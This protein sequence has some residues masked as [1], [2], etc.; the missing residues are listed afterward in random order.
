[1][2]AVAARVH[3]AFAVDDS[4][5]NPIRI[6]KGSDVS[7]LQ[8]SLQ[9]IRARVRAR[10]PQTIVGEVQRAQR[11]LE[12]T[13]ETLQ[14]RRW[15]RQHPGPHH[16]AR[17][18]FVIGQARSGTSLT[19]A[20]LGRHP[21]IANW[22]EQ[23]RFFDGAA[24]GAADV[25][26][27]WGAD[28]AT[29]A[30]RDRLHARFEFQRQAAGKPRFMNKYPR[31]SVRIDYLQAIFPD[32]LF[33]HVVRDGRAVARSLVERLARYPRLPQDVMHQFVRPPGWRNLVRPDQL[34][35]AILAWDAVVR[36]VRAA[37]PA[38]G[39]RYLE[40][41]YEAFCAKTPEVLGQLCRF[42]GVDDS[43]AVIHAMQ[44]TPL[45][46]RNYKVADEFNA[47]QLAMLERHGGAL[48]RD[49][50]YE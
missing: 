34:E 40:F 36:H 21:Q 27:A 7:S 44:P 6:R 30:E 26:H 4:L 17:P 9:Q 31:N 45:R 22:S 8:T 46:S 20:I 3:G 23:G 12:E 10:L 25:D 5:E 42:A 16:V 43:P 35:E 37:A 15:L 1:V 48:L 38:L 19:I 24:Y 32:A 39:D 41:T 2:T 13:A 49:L 28:R 29:P 11:R 47:D 18:I 50:G 33:V 14:F